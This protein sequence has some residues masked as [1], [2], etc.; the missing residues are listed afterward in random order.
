M[1]KVNSFED[2][3]FERIFESTQSKETAIVLSERLRE[4]VGKIDHPIADDLYELGTKTVLGDKITLLDYDDEDISKFTYTIPS[5]L[6]ELVEKDDDIPKYYKN[7]LDDRFIMKELSKEHPNVWTKYRNSSTIGKVINKLFPNKYKPNGKPG[8]DIESFTNDVKAERKRAVDQFDR[9]KIVDGDDILRYYNSKSYDP[10]AFGGSN[11]GGS[12]MRH[13]SCGDYIRFYSENKGVKLVVLMSENHEDKIVGRALLWDLK[14]PSDRKFMDRI[15]YVTDTDMRLFKDFAKKNEWLYKRNQNMYSDCE[16][17]D[18]K[19]DE[20]SRM[21]LE[22][23]DT[24]ET[25][26]YYPYM[27][28]MKY[29]HVDYGYLT[30]NEDIDDEDVYFL[31]STSGDYENMNGRGRYVDFYGER[32]D[33]EDLV[34]CELGDD[35]RLPDDAVWIEDEGAYATQ[36]YAENHYEWSDHEDRYIPN[37]YAVWSEYHRSSITAENSIDVYSAGVADTETFEEMTSQYHRTD[38]RSQDE[39]GNSVIEY[40][41]SDGE[42]YYFDSDDEEFFTEVISLKNEFMV[43]AHK[44]WDKDRIFRHNGKKY[45]DDAGSEVMDK[46]IGQKRLDF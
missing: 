2:Y 9:F 10:D 5:K 31:E 27:D 12:C 22:T 43:N 11:L 18:T 35:W 14:R 33:E 24:F 20:V 32:I 17:V 3:I 16:I 15:Y 42:Y 34:Y 44:V 36:R 25:K 41:G 39:V 7:G 37:D 21:I 6:L 46:L 26:D 45:L 28:T 13:S 8:E 29:F 19:T 23:V 4:L 1:K 40:I 30:N 38:P